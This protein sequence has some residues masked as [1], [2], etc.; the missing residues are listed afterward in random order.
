MG[1][2]AA[3]TPRRGTP[4][5]RPRLGSLSRWWLWWWWPW[6]WWKRC[7]HWY[8]CDGGELVSLKQ[9][10]QTDISQ[11]CYS[12]HFQKSPNSDRTFESRLLDS[13]FED[14]QSTPVI[15]NKML[16]LK[17]NTNNKSQ[18][19]YKSQKDQ[20]MKR[21]HKKNCRLLTVNLIVSPLKTTSAKRRRWSGNN[22][23][24]IK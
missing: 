14:Q 6:R 8:W 22:F 18:M 21:F 11:I 23:G 12:H 15:K 1:R 5:R 16:D 13:E 10:S 20:K 2:A 3:T 9:G 4:P 17:V 19:K 7:W 24:S